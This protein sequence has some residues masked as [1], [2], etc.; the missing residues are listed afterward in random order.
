MNLINV[1]KQKDR[2]YKVLSK[3]PF[4]P[5]IYYGDPGI[6]K[7]ALA[8]VV[9]K[10]KGL[11]IFHFNSSDERTKESYE[12]LL[13]RLQS[14]QL[15]PTLFLLDEIDGF[16]NFKR[17]TVILKNN[18]N[19]IICTCNEFWR[20]PESIKKKCVCMRFYKPRKADIVKL[21]KEKGV[22][23]NYSK[24]SYDVRNSIIS[25]GTGTDTYKALSDF[26]KIKAIFRK[27]YDGKYDRKLFIWILDNIP[28][29]YRGFDIVKATEI[30]SQADLLN[31]PEI[32]KYLPMGSSSDPKYPYYLTRL[33]VFKNRPKA[34]KK[35]SKIKRKRRSK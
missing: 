18:K 6:G 28:T 26:E 10:D 29:F 32:L 23:G 1:N 24:T 16:K 13:K 14:N 8:K 34:K 7:T 19:P 35:P 5:I 4:K 15:E 3:K 31:K 25:V 21:M 9:A 11:R 17:L 20:I 12:A 2:T 22:K 30:L 27:Q 33:K